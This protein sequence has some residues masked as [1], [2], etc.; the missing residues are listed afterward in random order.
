MGRMVVAA[1]HL[2][3]EEK[4]LLPGDKITAIELVT[5][6]IGEGYSAFRGGG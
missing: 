6:I 4:N 1:I 2:A 3:D 5:P